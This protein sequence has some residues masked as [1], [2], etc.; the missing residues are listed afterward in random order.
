MVGHIPLEDGIG[1]RVPDPQPTSEDEEVLRPAGRSAHCLTSDEEVLSRARSALFFI[2]CISS[3]S[4]NV[5]MD[6]FTRV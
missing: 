1:V 2:L 6:L 4:W 3:I 5:K